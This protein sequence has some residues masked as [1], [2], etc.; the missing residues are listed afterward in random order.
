MNAP[1]DVLAALAWPLA[2]A[3]AVLMFVDEGAFHRVR[4]LG[5]WESWGHVAD[6]A[7]FAGALAPAA[8]LA[9]THRA[10]VLYALLALVSTVL[11][12]KDE[13]IHT[14]ECKAAEN[15][16]HALLFALHPCV[17]IAVGALWARGE[18]AL[19]RA[20]LPLAVAAY[21]CYQW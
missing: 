17:L 14:R 3:Q 18:G 1:A 20:A 9:P 12:T 16:V 7:F 8:L 5:A 10:A 15:W 6:S 4:R 2:G 13:W 21:S 19:L 11:V